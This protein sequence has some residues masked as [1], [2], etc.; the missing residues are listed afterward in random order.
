MTPLE[1][2]QEIH[3]RLE[4]LYS[5]FNSLH[6]DIPCLKSKCHDIQESV[7]GL[8]KALKC[9]AEYGGE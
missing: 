4:A 5:S 6:S 3:D 1:Q 7:R 9:I 2:I 8:E